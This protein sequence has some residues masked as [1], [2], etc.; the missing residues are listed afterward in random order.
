MESQI[1]RLKIAVILIVALSLAIVI[2]VP[3]YLVTGITSEV[4]S[5][6]M[7]TS[8]YGFSTVPQ[9]IAEDADRLATELFGDY[10]ERRDEFVRQLLVTY[11]EAKDKDFVI[12]FNSGGA[13]W[14]LL[15]TS[16][17]WSSIF[18]GITH[19]LADSGYTSL[20]LDYLRTDKSWQGFLDEVMNMISLYPSKSKELASRVEF[21]TNY[22][23]N[24]RV[25]LTGESNGTVICDRVQN[26]L[27]D[28]P[29]VYSI[30][31]GPPFWYKDTMLDRKLVL[32]SSGI[33]PD[34]FSEG[35]ILTMLG[36][37]LEDLLGFPRQQ[38]ESGHILRFV[39]AP[40]HD[41]WW[42]HPGVSPEI[43]RF[44]RENFGVK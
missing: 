10:Q 44:L 5:G 43:T 27:K 28:N 18:D 19:E 2:V 23:P 41:Y 29:R 16:V 15:E 34:S 32:K 9:D 11:S 22:I 30:Q 13:G 12:F 37:T 14:N 21:L 4:G 7:P 38:G 6:G 36:A 39:G 3:P 40:G 33:I 35:H 24:L 26:A 8:I 25:I 1:H 42:Q 20:S 31:T 17:G